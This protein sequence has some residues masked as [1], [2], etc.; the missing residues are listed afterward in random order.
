MVDRI[1]GRIVP[2]ATTISATATAIPANAANGRK[3]IMLHNAGS[4]T[5]YLGHATVTTSNGLPL[6]PSEKLAIDLDK[7]VVIYGI[8]ATST[9]N[10]RSL[11]G[12]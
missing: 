12:V 7:E 10:I 6:E 9:E 3:S 4:N 11:E 5:I 2:T 8:V 1:A